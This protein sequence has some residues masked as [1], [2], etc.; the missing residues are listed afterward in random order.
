VYQPDDGGLVELGAG[1]GEGGVMDATC[2]VIGNSQ[3]T[4]RLHAA[5]PNQL[6]I[7]I[8]AASRID[9]QCGPCVLV[10]DPSTG[11]VFASITDC[12]GNATVS[13]P[14]QNSPRLLG[15][16]LLEQWVVLAPTGRC[17]RS[18]DLSNAVR[19]TIQ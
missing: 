9:A 7:L 3:F 5:A 13:M 4:Q 18:A 2:A 6:A 11:V 1:C 10:P 14:L 19:V 12:A 16:Q 8:L 15:V 17:S